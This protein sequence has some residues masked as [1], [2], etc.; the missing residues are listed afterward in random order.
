[1]KIANRK[2]AQAALLSLDAA[3]AHA[4]AQRAAAIAEERNDLGAGLREALQE[5]LDARGGDV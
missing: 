3:E 1:M 4:F 2:D 5:V